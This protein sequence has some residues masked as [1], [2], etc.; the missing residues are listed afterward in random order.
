MQPPLLRG[1]V[2]CTVLISGRDVDNEDRAVSLQPKHC[3]NHSPSFLRLVKIHGSRIRGKSRIHGNQRSCVY[4]FEGECKCI[5]NRSWAPRELSHCFQSNSIL[6]GPDTDTTPT[7][8]FLQIQYG[9]R[10][11]VT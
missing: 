4:R 3:S 1:L 9:F 11:P 7:P 8:G 5:K 6:C 10:S 2:R